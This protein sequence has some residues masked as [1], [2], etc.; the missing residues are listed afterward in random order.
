MSRM[1]ID[2]GVMNKIVTIPLGDKCNALL[3]DLA[4]STRQSKAAVLRKLIENTTVEQLLAL[5][6]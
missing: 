4:W 6:K 1:R 2:N 5:G 3:E